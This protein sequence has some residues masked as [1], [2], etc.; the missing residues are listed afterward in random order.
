MNAAAQSNELE[1]LQPDPIEVGRWLTENNLGAIL[2]VDDQLDPQLWSNLPEENRN[3]FIDAVEKHDELS[4]WLKKEDLTPP[5]SISSAIS[6]GY[7]E[8]LRGHL[9]EETDLLG[10]WNEFVSPAFP[11]FEQ[12]RNVVANLES[13]N[14]PEIVASGVRNPKDPPE[15]LALIL[16]DYT[17]DDAENIPSLT[18]PAHRSTAS[19][20]ELK[21]IYDELGDDPRPI[22]VLMSAR[23]PSKDQQDQFREQ[24]DTMPGMFYFTAKDKLRGGDLYYILGCI[25]GTL[26]N[27]SYLQSFNN[28]VATATDAAAKSVA[29][30]V[31]KLTLEDYAHIQMLGLYGD[32]HPLGEYV[33]SLLSEYF[34]E[35][36]ANNE[37]VSDNQKYI[38]RMNFEAPPM[39]SAGP[40]DAFVKAYQAAVYT[41]ADTNLIADDYPPLSEK[42]ARNSGE[43][44]ERVSLHFGDLFVEQESRRVYMVATPACDLAFGGSRPFEAN[45]SVL[46]IPG[47][48]KR[49][50]RMTENTAPRARTDLF[51]W[52]DDT[53]TIYWRLKQAITVPI[54]EFR[55]WA[56]DGETTRDRVKRIKFLFAA[57]IQSAYASDLT[58]VGVP[59]SPPVFK[60]Y[61]ATAYVKAPN[62]K[63]EPLL[64][65]VSNG[66]HLFTSPRI[67]KCL[68]SDELIQRLREALPEAIKSTQNEPEDSFFEKIPEQQKEAAKN[69]YRDQSVEIS[70]K[71]TELS[72]DLPGILRL[73]GLHDWASEGYSDD[74]LTIT[75]QPLNM[76]IEPKSLLTIL[77]ELLDVSSEATA[78][79]VANQTVLPNK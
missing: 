48:L 73:R 49:A 11:G 68:L 74:L 6:D 28:E 36:L 32:G 75:T 25:A 21:R 60:T 52:R 67:S 33:L 4:A 15:N 7:L 34:V 46:L 58:R 27:A 42:A 76:N 51:G 62:R 35:Q 69:G 47:Q 65:P 77:L 61:Q 66:G 24:T 3:G 44:A 79:D 38:D 5:T 56:E 14:G 59:V 22:V 57:E 26:P 2:V 18:D 39:E 17:L 37:H 41:S 13:L 63:P 10:L 43:P 19:I 8:K 23:N 29:E 53:W 78:S 72:K 54:G 9:N 1:D 55:A 16:M 12:I 70:E 31:K 50:N 20:N 40:T 30:L 45:T 64:G 71:L